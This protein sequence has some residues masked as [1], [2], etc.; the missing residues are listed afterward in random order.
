M[1]KTLITSIL[2]V[3]TLSVSFGQDTIPN[4]SFE[5]WIT[6]DTPKNWQ[7]TNLL[8]PLGVN[9]CS[10][11]TDSHTG[12]YALFMETINLD[13]LIVPG[14]ATLGTIQFNATT[15]GV[16]FDSKP[17]ALKG[18]Y[19]HPSAGNLA[20]IGVEFFKDGIEIGDAS[21]TITDSVSDYIEFSIP[22][23]YYSNLNPDT[24]NIT[25]LTDQFLEGNSL[26]IDDLEFV[27]E[28]A[29]VQV[30]N[31][32][33]KVISYPNPSQGLF[34]FDLKGK[35]ETEIQIYNLDGK[36]IKELMTRSNN[37]QV[38]LSFCI[39]GIYTA[40]IKQGEEVFLE[41]IILN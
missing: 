41:K 19:K 14:V 13:G 27:Y 38:D 17:V 11:S 6:F 30:Y 8:L 25:I 22:I 18:F 12:M 35:S 40:I 7:T 33:N 34:T 36:L 28:T 16:P 3:F 31:M 23:T 29:E 21:W 10:Q 1:K 5:N 15:G 26:L 20:L 32:G 2:I 9:N 24:L 37:V 39:P 4:N